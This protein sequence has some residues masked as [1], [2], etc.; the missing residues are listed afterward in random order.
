MPKQTGIKVV[1]TIV[2]PTGE[3][4]FGSYRVEDRASDDLTAFEIGKAVAKTIKK[5]RKNGANPAS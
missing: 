5:R 4:V 1:C 2:Y 3:I